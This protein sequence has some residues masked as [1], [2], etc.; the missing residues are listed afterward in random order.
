MVVP[1]S[2]GDAPD[3]LLSSRPA[4]RLVAPR[5]AGDFPDFDPSPTSLACRAQESR[6]RQSKQS[7]GLLPRR[8]ERSAST[9]PAPDTG[10]ALPPHGQRDP[11]PERKGAGPLR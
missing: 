11:G 10:G 8:E 2:V 3:L 5:T 9:R 4:G 1:P 7:S 6:G